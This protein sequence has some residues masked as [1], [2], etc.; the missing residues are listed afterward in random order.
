MIHIRRYSTVDHDD[1][2]RVHLLVIA[3]AGVEPTHQHYHDILNI[4]E[5]YLKQ[6]GEFLVGTGEH[7]TVFAIGG[8]KLLGE[9]RAE[10]K[11]LRV[12]PD[13][14]KRGYGQMMLSQLEERA[15]K[16]GIRQLYL[17]TLVNQHGA[18]K[19]FATNGYVPQG[20]AQIDGFDVL[21]YEKPLP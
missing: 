1:V 5:E 4:D 18:Q 12:H 20:P 10:I 21:I 14:Q 7:G 15:R 19:L 17:D 6:G 8:L 2:W 11:R 3:E 13:Y 16:L 9:G